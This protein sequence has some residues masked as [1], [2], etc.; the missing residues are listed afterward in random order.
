MRC[1]VDEDLD[2]LR[3][4]HNGLSDLL[5]KVIFE[6][7]NTLPEELESAY[8]SYIPMVGFLLAARLQNPELTQTMTEEQWEG[9]FPGLNFELFEGGV[10][11][12]KNG[13]CRQLDAE[14]GDTFGKISEREI[15]ITVHLS[16]FILARTEQLMEI[17]D[18]SSELDVLLSMAQ[19]GVE[20]NWRPAAVV[21]RGDL[22]IVAGRHPL[23]EIVRNEPFVPNSTLMCED[24]G[25]PPSASRGLSERGDGRG[26]GGGKTG[27]R[28]TIP[29]LR[30]RGKVVV[31][32]GPNACGKSVYLKQVGLIVYMAHLGCW[33]PAE[34][35]CVPLFDA[36]YTRIQTVESMELGLSAFMVD[37]NQMAHA[38]TTA[39]PR[40]LVL[41]DEFGKVKVTPIFFTVFFKTSKTRFYKLPA[42]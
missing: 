15:E 9:A 29:D 28:Q 7:I 34:S 12:F 21:A 24:P 42:A 19:A 6:D 27:Q 23:Q 20:Q 17:V 11:H 10:P 31:L 35:A 25:D 32:T 18:L 33:I 2:E 30:P 40:S 14:I 4:L 38:I 37:L 22:D 16:N 3:R 39:T 8:Y 1:G 36:I 41:V 5:E 13:R 26:S